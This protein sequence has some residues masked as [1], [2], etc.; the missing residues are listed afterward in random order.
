MKIAYILLMAFGLIMSS[1][2][3]AASFDCEKTINPVEEI[4]CEQQEI[5]DLDDLLDRT[6]KT[7]LQISTKTISLK[8][9]Q[10]NWLTNVRNRCSD[11]ACLTDAYE[12]RIFELEDRWEKQTNAL[13]GML[14]RDKASKAKPFEGN[15]K[16]CQLFKAE[17][18]CSSYRLIQNGKRICGEL[19]QWATYRIYE[20]R[21]Q[22]TIQSA[23]RAS[24]ELFCGPGSETKCTYENGAQEKWEKVKSSLS[25]CGNQLFDTTP[26]KP[27]D[28]LT[29]NRGF[30]YQTL[31]SKE[32]EEILSQP[33][34]NRC[35]NQHE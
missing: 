4:I 21:L 32:R 31:T 23:N 11:A 1:G 10:W 25:V 20:G 33:W 34:A 29:A 35:M 17:E 6:Y 8:A 19:E 16:S 22:A 14:V 26:A 5:S 18:I 24:V 9:D 7:V 30:R 28:A 15:W 27:C 3:H 12:A 13:N 2:S